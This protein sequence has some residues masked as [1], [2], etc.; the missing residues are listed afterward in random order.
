MNQRVSSF[1]CKSTDAEVKSVCVCYS[2]L[3]GHRILCHECVI[4]LLGLD[5]LGCWRRLGDNRF[6]NDLNNTPHTVAQSADHEQSVFPEPQTRRNSVWC[7]THQYLQ[8]TARCHL[9]PPV[10]CP[11]NVWWE[12][13]MRQVNIIIDII[14]AAT[15]K[16]SSISKTRQEDCESS[17]LQLIFI[18][19]IRQWHLVAVVII[20][21][22][23]EEV[24]QSH[25]KSEKVCIR[26][27]PGTDGRVKQAQDFDWRDSC[28]YPVW[29]DIH[30][31]V[32]LTY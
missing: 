23:K 1:F 27:S 11:G 8:I 12:E 22:A 24:R 13:E 5:M 26:R 31:W 21:A 3:A 9:Q 2:F 7:M 20:T 25:I 28:S 4:P 14:T 29:R 32:L 19:L 17:L 15:A 18:L 10:C 16:S 30:K 6:D